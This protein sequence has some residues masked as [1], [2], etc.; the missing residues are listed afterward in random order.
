MVINELHLKRLHVLKECSAEISWN[1]QGLKCLH[2]VI[3][4]T[5][6]WSRR[7]QAIPDSKG[8]GFDYSYVMQV[9]GNS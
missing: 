5:E 3:P 1:V 9:L 8:G 7:I 6:N 4:L 2:S